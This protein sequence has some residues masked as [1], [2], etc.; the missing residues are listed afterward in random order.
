[1]NVIFI[2]RHHLPVYNEKE[3]KQSDFS[4]YFSTHKHS[5]I[6]VTDDYGNLLGYIDHSMYKHAEK[7]TQLK[8]KNFERIIERD[9]L[10]STDIGSILSDSHPY[11][12]VP[13]MQGKYFMGALVKNYSEELVAFDRLMNYAA[14]NVL[15]LFKTSVIEYF[16]KNNIRSI[17]IIADP[18]DCSMIESI[19]GEYIT[20]K[21]H[22]NSLGEIIIDMGHSKSYR[23]GTSDYGIPILSL[24]ELL[25]IV[26]IPLI[27]D[28]CECNEIH[29]HIYEGPVKEKLNNY[30]LH[31]LV[32][33]ECNTFGDAVSSK[34][35]C[36]SFSNGDKRVYDY[37][38]NPRSG[39]FNDNYVITNG[40]NLLMAVPN[41]GKEIS[42][43][44]AVYFYGPCLTFG[45]CVPE[46][47]SIPSIVEQ[48][49]LNRGYSVINCGVKNGHSLLN[50][51]L[52]ILNTR[53]EYNDHIIIINA[54]T[55]QIRD[56]LEESFDVIEL[57][58]ILNKNDD[59]PWYFLDNTFH[60]NHVANQIIANAIVDS[61]DLL[62]IYANPLPKP[63]K[64]FFDMQDFMIKYN[65]RFLLDRGLLGSYKEY[66]L[67]HK[68]NF[69]RNA[70]VGAVLLTA[71]P[72]TLG[73]EYLITFAKKQCDILY[74][75]I[76]EED[77]FYFST[78]E[79]MLLVH[80]VIN[81]PNIIVLSTGNLMTAKFTFPE[82]F[83]KGQQ[84]HSIT[85][86]DIPD[87]HCDIFG[88]F[89]CPLLGI[90]TRFVGDEKSDSVTAAYNEKLITILPKYGV[91]V[92]K[93]HRLET[94]DNIVISS[95]T[96]R[97][98]IE[99]KS[100]SLLSNLVSKPIQEYIEAKWKA[101]N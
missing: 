81:D 61:V 27:K 11:D 95:S 87:I 42:E 94:T 53:F 83:S 91:D 70:K 41:R 98:I 15:G 75:F 89:V 23:K 9:E 86:K 29:V 80:D 2:D 31:C 59:S 16:S 36:E 92:V 35:I 12:V 97:R 52:Y 32:N 3:L 85:H 25:T 28:Y 24:E 84:E 38:T 101:K 79:R 73:H 62:P 60:V 21:S 54:F 13:L 48:L 90:N 30:D 71:N 4:I 88:G 67:S 56:S 37:L 40:I 100:F 14:L 5:P 26:L 6:F 18:E 22:G 39:P 96:V 76:V 64:S 10:A 34:S 65:G 1:M 55:R 82:Y 45:A 33:Q 19:L 20:L 43:G 50:D 63:K 99:S 93:I 69:K 68:I 66:L 77:M 78:A 44:N 8:P 49:I 57:S 17:S 58:K 51:F 46:C 47:L 74:V 7:F 72:I